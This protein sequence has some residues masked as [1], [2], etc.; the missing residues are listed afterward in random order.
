M[1]LGVVG[2]LMRYGLPGLLHRLAGKYGDAE[3]PEFP[4]TLPLRQAHWVVST[5]LQRDINLEL[6]HALRQHGFSG[7]IAAAVHDA[8]AVACLQQAGI[9]RVLLPFND[10]ATTAAEFL[11]APC[12]R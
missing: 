7:K 5:I 12:D 10:A 11:A 6:A 1:L 9:D 3:D 4:A 8:Y 2:L